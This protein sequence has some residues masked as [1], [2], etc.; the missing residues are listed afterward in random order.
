MANPRRGEIA[1]TID[2]VPRRLRLTL[3]AL[4]EL[5]ADL[6]ADSLIDL[7]ERF[8]TGKV[9]AVDLLALLAAGLAGAGEEIS[10]ADLAQAEIAGGA[11]GAMRAG[12]ALL[13]AAFQP[14][15]PAP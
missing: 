1:L 5:E 11:T 4:A 3:G 14:A 9:T 10:R 15:G 8:E 12:L 7:A 2:G 6:G 13:A